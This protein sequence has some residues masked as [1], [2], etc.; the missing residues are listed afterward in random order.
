MSFL[1]KTQLLKA[2][3]KGYIDDVV[4]Q[5]RTYGTITQDKSFDIDE[6]YHTGAH[7]VFTVQH[8]GYVWDVHMHNGEVTT[9]GYSL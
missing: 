3:N 2:Y 1:S 4:K 8:H 6:G 7:R 9:L 5:L